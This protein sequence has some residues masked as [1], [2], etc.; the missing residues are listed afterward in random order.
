MTIQELERERLEA[1][2]AHWQDVARDYRNLLEMEKMAA[3]PRGDVVEEWT[4]EYEYAAWE[5][6][7]YTRR[8]E[9]MSP[10]V[11]LAGL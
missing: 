1:A 5:V 9:G 6:A 3:N 2:L 8:L 11:A 10:S 7:Y 4:V